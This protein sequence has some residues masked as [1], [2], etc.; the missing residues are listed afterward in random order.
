MAAQIN[1]PVSVT[2]APQAATELR[3]VKAQ[4]DA[5]AQAAAEAK[6]RAT[7]DMN[8]YMGIGGGNAN[9]NP[10]GLTSGNVAV[11]GGGYDVSAGLGMGGAEA[12]ANAYKKTAAAMEEAHISG[13]RLA[14]TLAMALGPAAGEAGRAI[15]EM[16]EVTELLAGAGGPIVAGVA[17]LAAMAAAYAQVSEKAEEATRKEAEYQ[18]KLLE[19][20]DQKHTEDERRSRELASAGVFGRSEEASRAAE[21]MVRQGIPQDVAD[22]AAVAEQIARAR[23]VAFNQQQYLAGLASGGMQLP[24]LGGRD[25]ITQVQRMLA[26]GQ[27]GDAKAAWTAFSRENTPDPET[28]AFEAAKKAHPEIPER[29]LMAALRMARNGVFSPTKADEEGLV[30]S[31]WASSPAFGSLYMSQDALVGA[32]KAFKGGA[33]TVDELVAIAKQIAQEKGRYTGQQ[34]DAGAV[35]INITNVGVVHGDMPRGAGQSYANGWDPTSSGGA[36]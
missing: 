33:A 2:G 21:K 18:S 1:I 5:V 10:Y 35:T 6:A 30:S 25:G 16:S 11:T 14:G 15:F 22:N 3:A 17:A 20:K 34:V 36:H 12:Q 26:A 27:S 4:I 9:A 8:A 7:A 29:E 13:R 23:G 32:R 31:D 19:R 28:R 24:E